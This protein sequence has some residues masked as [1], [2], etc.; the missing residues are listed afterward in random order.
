MNPV[1]KA[2]SAPAT[3]PIDISRPEAQFLI[4][5]GVIG[6]LF[7]GY[8]A[9]QHMFVEGLTAR[10]RKGMLVFAGSTLALWA[11][12]QFYTLDEIRF[13]T[14]EGVAQKIEQTVTGQ[15]TPK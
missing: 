12:E 8:Q 7:I 4:V 14:P 3:P 6:G 2:P 10:E 11:V 9:Y 13:L 1:A 15:T 5:T